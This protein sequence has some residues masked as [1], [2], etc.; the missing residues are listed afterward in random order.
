MSPFRK[1]L[2]KRIR[3]IFTWKFV[4]YSLVLPGLRLVGAARGDALLGR[5][6][7]FVLGLRPGETARM[8]RALDSAARALDADW[9]VADTVPLLAANRARFLARDYPLDVEADDEVLDRFESRGLDRLWGALAGGKG[10]ILVGS[11]F[12]A[13]IAGLH[14]LFRQGAPLRLLVQRPPHVSRY[15]NR[16]FDARGWHPQSEFFLRRDLEP[17]AA[18]LRLCRARAALRDGLVVYLNGDIPWT[19]CNTSAG[20]LLGRPQRL[21]AIWPLLASLTGAPVFLVFCRHRPGGR[22]AIEL[23]PLERPRPGEEETAVVDYLKQLEARIALAPEEAVAH[24]LWP[25]YESNGRDPSETPR[26]AIPRRLKP[27]PA[28]R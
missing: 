13:H 25:C 4:F 5:L 7:R 2:R 16:R 23:E 3:R 28:S 20:Y 14:W 9:S 1:R 10:A 21:L 8:S 6:G 15:L 19:G 22:F 24:L 11:H 12:G 18:A 17:A 27:E 26:R